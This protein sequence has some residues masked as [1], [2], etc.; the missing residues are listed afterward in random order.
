[1]SGL[2]GKATP[3]GIA[4]DTERVQMPDNARA[5][6]REAL[7]DDT[8]VNYYQPI[9]DI[10]TTRIVSAES[11]LRRTG[12]QGEASGAHDLTAAAEHGPDLVRLDQWSVRSAFTDAARWQRRS[13][14]VRVNVNLSPR[15][16]EKESLVG[17]I[18]GLVAETGVVPGRVNL[19][20]TETSYIRDPSDTVA[21]LEQLKERGFGLWLDDFGTGHSSIEHLQ[22]FPLDGLKIPG[23]FIREIARSSRCCSIVRAVVG[24]AHDLGLA[25]VCEEVETEEQ[26]EFVRRAGANFIQGFL[27]SRPMPVDDFV[28]QLLH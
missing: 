10:A 28:R 23:G 4:L 13:E 7:D 16:F 15:E 17:R 3:D 11:L 25:V 1:V 5:E 26:L 27:F 6:L 21:V 14:E 20:I 24:L 22:H 2:S 9:H 19:E 12:H 8:L 18:D